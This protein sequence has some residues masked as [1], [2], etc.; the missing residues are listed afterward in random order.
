MGER[1]RRVSL[2]FRQ[3]VRPQKS[4]NVLRAPEIERNHVHSVYE[5]IAPHFSNTRHSGWPQEVSFIESVAEEYV[6]PM[7]ADIG[8]GNGKYL[9]IIRTDPVL[10]GKI[11][12]IGMDFSA[13][14]CKIVANRRCQAFVGDALLIPFH[15]ESFEAVLNIA[16]LHHISERHRRL[17]LF[18]EL[19]RITKKGGRG[20]VCAWAL[21]QD[22]S[23]RHNF[24][25]AD[26][27]VPWNL[28]KKKVDRTKEDD[29]EGMILQR[30]CHVYR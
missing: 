2:T 8:C 4:L 17:R 6:F 27:F 30:Y 12:G 19:F 11:H 28:S 10:N 24:E 21:E 9:N 26:V 5:R 20:F 25:K 7:M 1:T 3:V 23:S 14:L 29:D 16:V 22:G 18:S 15:D 13:N